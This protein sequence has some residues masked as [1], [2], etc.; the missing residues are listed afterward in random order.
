M[1]QW[2]RVDPNNVPEG[3]FLFWY[4]GIIC[5]GWVI[6]EK[7]EEGYPLWEGNESYIRQAHGV[8]WYAERNEP[9]TWE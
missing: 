9:P 6:D 5:D 8:R 1:I 7:D 4:D 3:N 2:K